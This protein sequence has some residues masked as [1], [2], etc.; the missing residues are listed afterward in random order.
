MIVLIPAY[1]PDLRLVRLVVDLLAED[2]AVTVLVVD[3]GSGPAYDGVFSVASDAGAHLLRFPVNRGKGAA[4]RSGFA[5]VA[6]RGTGEPVVCADCDGQH[7]PEDVLRVAAEVA[8][9]T[10]VLGGRRFTGKVPARSRLGNAVSR[11]LFR[12]VAGSSVHD[13]QTGLRA[14][15]HDL[16]GWLAAVDGERFEYEFN[17]LLQA[18]SAGVRIREVGIATI[19]LAGNESSHFRP[20]RDSLRIYAPL[21]R[22]AASSLTSYAVDLALVVA[23]H[24]LTGNL[25]AA[26][27]VARIVSAGCNFHVNRT[28]VFAH[29]GDGLRAAVRY[30]L[31]AG[32]MLVAN[33]AALSALVDLGWSVAPAKVV[34]EALLVVASFAVQR[35]VV[36]RADQRTTMSS[37]PVPSSAVMTSPA[38][39]AVTREV[40]AR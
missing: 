18:A 4:L 12:A 3:D 5:W 24:A 7:T 36:F 21:L 31:L 28:L 10:M 35:R 39:V 25:L 38:P 26:V 33:Y 2:A 13:T 1:E 9:G 34:V 23:L 37:E 14:Y 16:L 22:F 8:P 30:A 20:V 15:P 6:D 17:L 27:L 11:W 40:E 29:R 19:Y 32:A